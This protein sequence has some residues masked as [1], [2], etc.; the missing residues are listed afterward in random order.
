MKSQQQKIDF[1]KRH[2]HRPEYQRVLSPVD[3]SDPR[4]LSHDI[5]DSSPE[6][7]LFAHVDYYTK[8]HP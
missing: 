1:D 3:C 6:D 7:D 5:E 8:S 2:T 4:A